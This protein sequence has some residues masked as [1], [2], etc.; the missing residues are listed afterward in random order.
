MQQVYTSFCQTVINSDVCEHRR[1][2]YDMD[3]SMVVFASKVTWENLILVVVFWVVTKIGA[4]V[5]IWQPK[6]M[7]I[8]LLKSKENLILVMVFWVVTKI[9][10][11]VIMWQSKKWE[12]S[13]LS[14]KNIFSKIKTRNFLIKSNEYFLINQ[15]R[16]FPLNSKEKFPTHQKKNYHTD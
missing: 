1:R 8:F 14:Q 16:N 9:G 10:A 3:V 5:I 11:F 2:I 4:F 6:K 15:T 12:F 7:G 13:S